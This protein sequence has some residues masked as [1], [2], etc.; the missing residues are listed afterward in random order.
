MGRTYHHGEGHH[1]HAAGHAHDHGHGHHHHGPTSHGRAFAIAVALNAAFVV[2]EVIAGLVSGSTALLADAGHNLG[3][4][5]SLLLAWGASVLAARPAGPGYTYGLK[6]SS[7]LAAI[8]N[9]AL[10]WVALGAVL[11]ESLRRLWEPV[12]VDGVQVMV[13][14]GIGIAVNLASAM[15]FIGG[16]K[17]DL[18]LRAAFLHLLA[19]AAVSA[20]VVLAGLAITLTAR[21]WIDPVTSLV[22]TVV[23][24]WVSW[25]LLRDAVRMGLL[26]VPPHIDEAAVRAYLAEQA[27]VEAVHDLHIWGM[28]TTESALTAHLVMPQGTG[29]DAFLRDV[30]QGLQARFG[31][32][33]ATLQIER[34]QSACSLPVGHVH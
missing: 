32:D 23:L 26:A 10:L 28:S 15:L 34:D 21:N 12:P 18:N 16:R 6:S 11:V 27:G 7:I 5:L 20:S 8:A 14:A 1:G 31:I 17:H 22:I 4:V 13:V 3:D 2:A 24:G 29:G 25:S 9:A 30:A 19:D 33:H